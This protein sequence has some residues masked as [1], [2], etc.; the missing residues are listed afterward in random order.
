MDN[1]FT[2]IRNDS[3]HIFY[4]VNEWDTGK[5]NWLGYHLRSTGPYDLPLWFLRDLIIVTVFTPLIYYMIR[6]FKIY[7]LV[8]LFV[9]YISR[10]WTTMPGFS[11]TSCFFFSL[12]AYLALNEINI[13]KAVHKYRM[14]IMLF[15]LI[16]FCFAVY[17][18]GSPNLI[19][20]TIYPLYICFAV[21]AAFYIASWSALTFKIKP[22]KFLVSNCFFI[23]ALHGAP[24]IGA[25]TVLTASKTIVTMCVPFESGLV[26]LLI[27]LITPFVAVTICIVA[28][29]LLYLISPKIAML[30][31]GNRKMRSTNI[32]GNGA[33]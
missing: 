5:V 28:L 29:K 15:F 12:G 27:Y 6:K 18:D 7:F 2:L 13:I 11:I 20:Q 19:G 14:L 4:D 1:V 9:A 10:V 31:S 26:E 32:L 22:N 33:D 24:I 17:Y 8:F 23:Y 16:L 25:V 30:F 21:L 3:W